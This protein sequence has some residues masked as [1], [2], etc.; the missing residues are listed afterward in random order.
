MFNNLSTLPP[1]PILGLIAQFNNDLRDRKID[2]G[3]GVYRDSKGETPILDSV[4]LAEKRILESERSKAYVGPLGNAEFNRAMAVL[5]LGKH[6]PQLESLALVQTPGGCGALRVAAEL[7]KRADAN[8]CIW[9]SDPTWGNH[10]P[11]LAGAGVTIKTYPYYDFKNHSI[12]FDSMMDALQQVPAGDLVLLHGC[13]HNP[14]GADLSPAQWQAITNLSAE[15]GFVPFIDSA[16]QGFGNG[17]AADAYG[18]RLMC[19]QLPEVVLALSCSKNFGLYRERVG[20][21]GVLGKGKA[22]VS[23][24][25]ASIVR[26]IYSMPPSHG[27]TVVSE[28]LTDEALRRAWVSE[29]DQMRGRID[30]MRKKLVEEVNAL[31]AAGRFDHIAQQQG[32]FSFLGINKGQVARMAEDHGIYMVD[33]SRISLAGLNESNMQTFCSALMNVI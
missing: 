1:D 15:N 24:H 8:A 30:S 19:E 29:V 2:L 4:K 18:I 10:V 16:Y 28:I 21:V 32:M 33:T 27:A 20:A 13:C 22:T 11:L 23:S 12:C 6:H 3:V 17:I 7:I 25:I 14:T 31:G 26:G 5:A 9:V